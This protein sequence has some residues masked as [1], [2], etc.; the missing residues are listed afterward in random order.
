MENGSL[1]KREKVLA[2]GGNTF[3][4]LVKFLVVTVVLII[5]S[6]LL[7]DPIANYISTLKESLGTE[8]SIRPESQIETKTITEYITEFKEGEAATYTPAIQV[9]G[10]IRR[11]SLF[12]EVEE[13]D[14][15]ST[16][17]DTIS[18]DLIFDT[19]DINLDGNNIITSQYTIPSIE[20]DILAD[21]ID[22]SELLGLLG[23]NQI[24]DGAVDLN[25]SEVSGTLPVSRGGTNA[26][27]FSSSSFIWYDGTRLTSSSYSSS[28][29][30]SSSTDLWVNTSGDSMTG[31]LTMT[32]GSSIILPSSGYLLLGNS[33]LNETSGATD[34]GAYTVGVFNEFGNS[35]STDVQGVL[36]DLDQAIID[37]GL[38]GIVPDS[39][40]FSEFEDSMDLDASTT[41]VFGTYN[42]NLNLNNSGDL[43]IQDAGTPFA[44]FADT[45]YFDLDN[46]RL[47]A[48]TVSS[49]SGGITLT[50]SNSN[51]VLTSQADAA[52]EAVRADRSISGSSGLSGGGDLTTNRSL[53]VN[54]AFDFAWTGNNSWGTGTATFN[55]RP[56]FNGGDVANSPFTVDSNF[57]VSSLNADLLDGS[58]AAAFMSAATD[59][60]VDETGDTMSNTLTFSGVATDIDVT[61]G[62]ALT[63]SAPGA[64]HIILTPGTGNVGIVATDPDYKFT[65]EGQ[66]AVADNEGGADS[67]GTLYLGRNSS[68]WESLAW[69]DT[70]DR[71][72]FSDDLYASSFITGTSL[73]MHDDYIRDTGDIN[74]Q[75]DSDTSNYFKIST[76]TEVNL[77]TVSALYWQGILDYS[78]APGFSINDSGE[79]VYRDEDEPG[80]TTL[81]SLGSAYYQLTGN[82]VN[83]TQATYDIAVGGTTLAASIFGIDEDTGNFYFGYDNSVNPTL[84][85]EATGGEAGTFGFNTNDAF[86]FSDA[87]VGIAAIDPSDFTLQ[88]NGDIGPDSAPT[89]SSQALTSTNV[90]TTSDM[91]LFSSIAI[92][93]D[94]LPIIAH[95]YETGADLRA[96]K[97]DNTTCTS[98]TCT[99]LDSTNDVGD[100]TSIAVPTDGLPVISYMYVTGY[101]LKVCKCSNTS[102]TAANCTT[103]DSANDVGWNTSIAI[104]TDDLPVISHRDSS[105]GDLRA[106]KCTNSSCTLSTC[107]TIDSAG[108]VGHYTSIAIG[109]DGLPII[110]HFDDTNDDLRVC[111]CDN[112]SCTSATCSTIDSGN[113]TG[114]DTSIAIGTDGLPIIA[115]WYETGYDLRV[116]KCDNSSCTSATCTTLDST[117][118]VGEFPSIAIGTDGLPVISYNDYTNGD[119]K[120]CKCTNTSCTSANCSTVDSGDWVGWESSIAIGTDGLP[121]ISH[122]NDTSDDLRVTK[123]GSPSCSY[124]PG[125]YWSGGSDIGSR[126]KFFNNT[127]ATTYW[128]REDMQISN[129]DVAE[130]YKAVDSSIS[131]GDIVAI[132]QRTDVTID[133]TKIAYQQDTI[134]V[135][136]TRPGLRLSDWDISEQEKDL[137]RPVALSGRVPVKVSTVNGDIQKGDFLTPSSKPGFAMKACGIKYC[138]AGTV[139]GKALEDFNSLSSGDSQA[140]IQEVGVQNMSQEDLDNGEGRILMFI[141]LHWFNPPSSVSDA[142]TSSIY[143][144]TIALW[145][146][147]LDL[148]DTSLV[149]SEVL[150]DTGVFK[151]IETR[152]ILADNVNVTNLLT[153]KE[154]TTTMLKAYEDEDLVIKLSESLGKTA[155]EIKNNLG[156]VVFSVDS[157]G[158]VS[159]TGIFESSWIPV[160]SFSQVKI[161]HNLGIIPRDVSIS[162]SSNAI[163]SRISSVGFGQE[164]GYFYKDL[165]ENSITVVNGSNNKIYIRLFLRK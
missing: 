56:A 138:Q 132:S 22:F 120:V 2:E 66:A 81:D 143:D 30:M 40:D 28:S 72:E 44:T 74:L 45:G 10:S 82:V 71:F 162:R 100:W 41:V 163:G 117:N 62:E 150:A 104:G 159:G 59:N 83:P 158:K 29:F 15:V 70:A 43:V 3:K 124:T 131:A 133:K 125:Y 99:T 89:P 63:I 60:W 148:T 54:Q 151:Q 144:N 61:S 146:G 145:S 87:S 142:A 129:F 93:T 153:S 5:F 20:I 6:I 58:E 118:N 48:N 112:I 14:W 33:Y 13:G 26:S 78:N 12:R 7:K 64:G 156:Q 106:C 114:K 95:H 55:N 154:I 126:D 137:M 76:G 19:A 51:I 149:V 139:I 109:T 23:D 123:C 127:Y 1:P 53:S 147:N 37:L 31:N 18:G 97:C 102:C 160:N 38:L 140:V 79:L 21:G 8:P 42:Y 130:D 47:D 110:S 39:L 135:V 107:T 121:I 4:T 52:N 157:K 11:T 111:K 46:L 84:L 134:G 90:D 25:T 69:N 108:D 27:S 96:C 94:N 88:V 80:W 152:S 65:V 165:N 92:G 9:A 128:A 32:G 105:T 161:N 85:F 98:T 68:A 24:S 67:D 91:G 49:T 75:A 119:L 36:D 122:Y 101:D 86:Y 116:C 77:E 115:H 136:S 141:N 103:V 50:A 17:G 113:I 155:F 164:D 57:L 34:S 16:S 73:T 35:L